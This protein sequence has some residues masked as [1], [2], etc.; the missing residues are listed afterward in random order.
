MAKKLLIIKLGGSVVTY[1]DSNKPRARI[2][3]IERLAKEIK[4]IY[5]LEKYQIILAHGAGS[6]AHPPSKKYDLPNGIHNDKQKYGFAF[7]EQRMLELNL[8]I[9]KKL[10]KQN[11]PV[12]SLPP[13]AFIQTESRRII[14]FETA[15]LENILGQNMIPLLFGDPILDTVQGGSI[16]SGDTIITYLAKK[17]NP[18][19]IIF[20]SDVDGIFD[21][22][23]KKNPNAKLISVI[24]NDNLE[25]VLKGITINNSYDISGE[26]RGK[27]LQVFDD[28]KK[29]E[30]I[31]M[32]GLKPLPVTAAMDQ[33]PTATKLLFD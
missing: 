16:L 17:F 29:T 9:T 32:N 25:K 18:E 26:M 21:S 19:K 33:F 5:S 7:T 30:V 27:I 13:R 1:K 3:V 11:L 28:L 2:E 4:Q 15:I 24:N 6:F 14:K 8:I 31:V 10:V 12:V 22:D 23:P 20:L